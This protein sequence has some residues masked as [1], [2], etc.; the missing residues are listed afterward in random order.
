MEGIGHVLIKQQIELGCAQSRDQLAKDL[1]F[2]IEGGFL[3][4]MMSHQW[5]LGRE[6]I[7][8]LF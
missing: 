6:N 4:T 2:E 5:L 8:Y 7:R 3:L 1:E